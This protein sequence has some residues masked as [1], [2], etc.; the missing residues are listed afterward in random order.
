MKKI[1]YSNVDKIT[2][3]LL[4][5]SFKRPETLCAFYLKVLVSIFAFLV[6]L[7]ALVAAPDVLIVVLNDFGLEFKHLIANPREVEKHLFFLFIPAIT[8]FTSLFL[9]FIFMIFFIF[10]FL[11]FAILQFLIIPI[12][13]MTKKRVKR[14]DVSSVRKQICKRKV[15]Y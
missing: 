15:N 5:G 12:A 10:V 13:N 6:Y 3:I 11:F 1:T 14:S 4:W 8:V 9:I 7:L 2:T